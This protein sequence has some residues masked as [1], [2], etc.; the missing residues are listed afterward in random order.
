M[1]YYDLICGDP[2]TLKLQNNGLDHDNNEWSEKRRIVGTEWQSLL[3]YEGANKSAQYLMGS[4]H[5]LL[6]LKPS[7]YYTGVFGNF[8]RVGDDGDLSVSGSVNQNNVHYTTTEPDNWGIPMKN[9]QS[10]IVLYWLLKWSQ[11]HFKI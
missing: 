1:I 11:V 3:I 10:H 6:Q 2:L 4:Q 5:I 8:R 9:L 7:G